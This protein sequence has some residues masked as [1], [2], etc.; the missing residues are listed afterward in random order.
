MSSV[1]SSA[2]MS[3]IGREKG[4][5][6]EDRKGS[7]L[8]RKNLEKGKIWAPSCPRPLLEGESLEHVLETVPCN[9]RYELN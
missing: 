8:G 3:F 1:S 6:R 5:G 2:I 9:I 7:K 4:E